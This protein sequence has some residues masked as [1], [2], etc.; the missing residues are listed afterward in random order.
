MPYKINKLKPNVYHIEDPINVFM[1][2]VVGDER[3]LLLDTGYG[4]D[5]LDRVVAQITKLPVIVVNSHAHLDHILG[6]VYFDEVY[7]HPADNRLYREHASQDRRRS[8]ASMQNAHP[9]RFPA[10]FS[11]DT[12]INAPDGK[13]LP[14]QED[15]VFSLG[16]V[17]LQVIHI[18]G[19]TPGG[20]ALLDD[21]D[22]LLLTG[23]TV[24]P[25]VWLFLK[26]STGIESYITS[27]EKLQNLR[28][29]Y[30]GI[31]ASHVPKVLPNEMVDRLI[32]CAENINPQES[33]P[34]SP[35]FDDLEPALMYYEGLDSLK[36]AM[37]LESLD[38]E[39]QPLYTLNLNSL[40]FSNV[41]FVSIVY[42]ESKIIQD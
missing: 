33:I 20:I 16:G 15:D 28:D 30:E 2:L 26:E 35:P 18:P 39:K 41:D 42:N 40:D 37:N 9:E 13:I 14:V 32:H 27:L 6:N 7:L 23:D 38:L 34:F 5:H 11:P 19:H 1:T 3:A 17:N 10:D 21:R 12:Y 29:R 4:V 8:I 36:K 25:H 24:S 22:R 31:V